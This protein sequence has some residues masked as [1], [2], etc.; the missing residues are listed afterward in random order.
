MLA[1]GGIDNARLLLASN[2]RFADG[3]GN[4]N[5]LVGRFF[6]EHPRF[7]AGVVAPRTRT[8]PSLSIRSTSST[9]PSS[10]RAWGS[11]GRPRDGGHRGRAGAD[12]SG[13][14][15]ALECAANSADVAHLKAIRDA[16]RGRDLG[17]MGDDISNVVADLMT[18]REFTVPGAP[19]P[20]RTRTWSVR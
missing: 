6:L 18:W 2:S 13:A 3:I 16:I 14:H 7:V 5:D 1:V 17:D 12:R 19:I 4:A 20:I 11:R 8:C 9:A 15:A 10:S